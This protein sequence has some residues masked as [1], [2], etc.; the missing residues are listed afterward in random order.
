M[1][2]NLI[3]SKYKYS[4]PLIDELTESIAVLTT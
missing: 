2:L 1:Y 3:Y 4:L